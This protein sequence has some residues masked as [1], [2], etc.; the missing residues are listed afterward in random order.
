MHTITKL[1]NY[2]PITEVP[3]NVTAVI[4]AVITMLDPDTQLFTFT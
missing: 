4:H 1:I 2:L 3:I